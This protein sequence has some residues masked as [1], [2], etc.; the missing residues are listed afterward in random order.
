VAERRGDG[1]YGC[2]GSRHHGAADRRRSRERGG[3]GAPAKPK[4]ARPLSLTAPLRAAM[5]RAFVRLW[6]LDRDAARKD[7]A[8]LARAASRGAEDVNSLEVTELQ[9]EEWVA[10]AVGLASN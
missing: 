4:M 6:M 1:R 7:Y 10:R 3:T 5:P 8:Q 9:A 2:C